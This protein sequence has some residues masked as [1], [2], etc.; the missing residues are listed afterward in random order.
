MFSKSNGLRAVVAAIL[1]AAVLAGPFRP[2]SAGADPTEKAA[3]IVDEKYKT[4]VKKIFATKCS[5]CH[6]GYGMKQADG[7]KLAGSDRSVE[8]LMT[9]IR[10]GKTPMPG[11]KN[12]LSD[13]EVRALAEYIKALPTD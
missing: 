13:V 12:Q 11:F 5:W 1:V 9:Q 3:A 10:N 7:P 4:D 2:A 6:Q 8:Q